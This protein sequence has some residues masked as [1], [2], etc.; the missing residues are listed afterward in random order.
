MEKKK[1]LYYGQIISS[2]APFEPLIKNRLPYERDR[3]LPEND[4]WKDIVNDLM[5][6]QLAH[7]LLEPN[8]APELVYR[9]TQNRD[10]ILKKIE[11][12]LNKCK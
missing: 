4:I 12:F 3:D 10:E 2:L 1:I 6:G 11:N 7:L 5:I 8:C 9:K